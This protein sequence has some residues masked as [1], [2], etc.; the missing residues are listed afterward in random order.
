MT[1]VLNANYREHPEGGFGGNS[2]STA[3]YT[4]LSFLPR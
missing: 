1:Q 3:K 4:I 2:V